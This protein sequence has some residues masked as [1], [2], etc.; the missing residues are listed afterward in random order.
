MEMMNSGSSRPQTMTVV[1]S[2]SSAQQPLFQMVPTT[3]MGETQQM[4]I[5]LDGSVQT[6]Q[7]GNTILLPIIP[8]LMPDGKI[9]MRVAGNAIPFSTSATGTSSTSGAMSFQIL[10][11][12]T[13]DADDSFQSTDGQQESSCT[14][15]QLT[16]AAA[17]G[18]LRPKESGT[19]KRLWNCE[20]CDYTNARRYLLVRHMKSHSEHRP[21]ECHMCE[22]SFKTA[23]S[24]ANHINTHT[25]LKPFDCDKCEMAFTTSGELVRHQRYRHTMEKPHKCPDCD[26]A[27]VELSKLKRHVRSHTGER[28]F[29]S[30][31]SRC[32]CVSAVIFIIPLTVNQRNLC[33][34]LQESY[35]AY[36]HHF[37]DGKERNYIKRSNPRILDVQL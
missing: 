10:Q 1:H 14:T 23:S 25:G 8:T 16:L 37:F 9:E 27:T 22:R 28:P 26:Y 21:H 17:T 31:V 13:L 5:P 7:A 3:S 35:V 30:V 18:R 4:M 15:D 34:F 2:L 29:K 24:L 20:F 19:A 11:Q 32:H 33:W 36:T 6:I 12:H